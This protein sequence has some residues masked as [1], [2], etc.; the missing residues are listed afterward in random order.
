MIGISCFMVNQLQLSMDEWWV[1][2]NE[3]GN[4]MASAK[5]KSERKNLIFF[6]YG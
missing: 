6:Q 5:A 4:N 1:D 2:N 3:V